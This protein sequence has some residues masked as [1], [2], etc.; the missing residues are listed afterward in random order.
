MVTAWITRQMLED[1]LILE[2]LYH[3]IW[4]MSRHC[5]QGFIGRV[6]SLPPPELDLLFAGGA[7]PQL[8]MPEPGTCTRSRWVLPDKLAVPVGPQGVASRFYTLASQD[9]PKRVRLGFPWGCIAQKRRYP[10]HYLSYTAPAESRR[11]TLARARSVLVLSNDL[12]LLAK[13]RKTGAAILA[14]TATPQ[15]WMK[16]F[17]APPDAPVCKEIAVGSKPSAT[18]GLEVF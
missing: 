8:D 5:L 12:T 17:L 11:N 1:I 7:A 18:S 16:T 10:H 4:Q 6:P 15:P 2:I 14:M 13:A 3:L 9:A